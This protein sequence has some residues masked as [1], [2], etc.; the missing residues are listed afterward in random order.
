M[1][2]ISAVA[3]DAA[4]IS[5]AGAHTAHRSNDQA[6]NVSYC[7]RHSQ[8]QYIF[9]NDE[10]GSCGGSGPVKKMNAISGSYYSSAN[11][12]RCSGNVRSYGLVVNNV[13]VASAAA[14]SNSSVLYTGANLTSIF[15]HGYSRLQK[16]MRG[17]RP[18]YLC[19]LMLCAFNASGEGCCNPGIRVLILSV[20]RCKFLPRM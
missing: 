1:I 2:P 3:D 6:S 8:S 18:Y 17:F 16:I 20:V 4:T 19:F 11:Y 14:T 10:Y 9:K 7:G 12:S 5:S 13:H 15:H